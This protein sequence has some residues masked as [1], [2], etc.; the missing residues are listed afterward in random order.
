MHK[1][2]ILFLCC[3]SSLTQS[4]GF[5]RRA[6]VGQ[7]NR[8]LV[9]GIGSIVPQGARAISPQTPQPRS[10][11][12]EI[13]IDVVRD[14]LAKHFFERGEDQRN[15]INKEIKALLAK[16]PEIARWRDPLTSNTLLHIAAAF[17]NVPVVNFLAEQ[18]AQSLNNRNHAGKTPLDIAEDLFSQAQQ[19]VADAQEIC[20]ALLELMHN[21]PKATGNK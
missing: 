9:A 15:A 7:M 12:V 21:P 16:D 2:Y 19:R 13:S 8:R 17:G 11:P 1:K 18:H 5:L 10:L 20:S 14:R 4:M 3:F 6:C